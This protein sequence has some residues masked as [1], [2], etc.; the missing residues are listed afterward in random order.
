MSDIAGNSDCFSNNNYI[1]TYNILSEGTSHLQGLGRVIQHIH[2]SAL[3]EVIPVLAK[4]TFDSNIS[5]RREVVSV[6]GSWLQHLVDRYIRH[7]GWT[8]S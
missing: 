3:D 2:N 4:K 1:H 5:V 7:V 6:I 8:Q